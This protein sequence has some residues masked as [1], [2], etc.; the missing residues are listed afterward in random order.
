MRKTKTPCVGICSTVFGDEVCRGCKRFSHE[1]ID[2]NQYQDEQKV[3]VLRRLAN[4]IDRV[5]ASK[6][7]VV[8]SAA[9]ENALDIVKIDREVDVTECTQIFGLLKQ[10]SKQ[11]S[12]LSDH[13]L[14]ALPPFDKSTPHELRE[15]ID[16][17]FLILSTATFE[18][19]FKRSYART[20]KHVASHPSQDDKALDSKRLI[21]EHD[22]D[23][24]AA[25]LNA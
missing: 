20:I 6:V 10:S 25:E 9:F 17:E 8:D 13:G 23:D 1:V 16:Q 21:V 14:S 19:S 18:T 5:V 15:I 12:R 4:L 11:M 7:V 22:G 3:L 24:F 2:W